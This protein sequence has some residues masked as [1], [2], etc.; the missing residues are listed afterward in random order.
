MVKLS[1]VS[2]TS[3]HISCDEGQSVWMGEFVLSSRDSYARTKVGH[4]IEMEILGEVFSLRVDSRTIRRSLGVEQYTVSA[5]SPL[6]FKDAPFA[7]ETTIHYAAAVGARKA[8]EDILNTDV[9]WHLPRWMIPAGALSMAGV[10][11]LQAARAIV[12]AVG[13][14]IESLPNGDINCRLRD[15]VNIPDYATATVDHYFDD[16]DWVTLGSTDA[17]AKGFNRVMISNST[18]VANTDKLEVI[19]DPLD[20]RKALIR[21]YLAPQRPVS[22][23]HTGAPETVIVA[24]GVIERTEFEVIEFV[25]G[26][27]SLKYPAKALISRVWQH[28]DL[29]AIAVSGTTATASVADGYSLAAVSYTVQTTDWQVSSSLYEN[30]Q[31]LLVDAK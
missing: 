1:S 5:I 18:S 22:L 13:G 3:A 31:F 21:A 4:V 29:G 23:V 6:G 12:E 11:P 9:Q 16:S 2:F 7:N 15:P 14:I 20:S 26:K 25:A 28:T 17:P 10:T 27:A 8:V 19:M 30:V 24:L